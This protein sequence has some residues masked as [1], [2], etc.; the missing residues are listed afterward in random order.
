MVKEKDIVGN[1]ISQK[2]KVFFDS[3]WDHYKKLIFD[4]RDDYEISSNKKPFLKYQKMGKVIFVGNGASAS[5]SES[6]RNRFN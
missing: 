6:C 1:K 3:Y 4:S 2:E 5:N